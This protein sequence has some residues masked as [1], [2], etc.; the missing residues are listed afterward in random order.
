M[1]GTAKFLEKIKEEINQSSNIDRIVNNEDWDELLKLPLKRLKNLNIALQ[2]ESK[3]LNDTFWICS[4]YGMVE[5]IKVDDPKS[6]VYHI[7]EIEK[8]TN[9]RP[10]KDSLRSIHQA[11][12]FFK[13]S[14]II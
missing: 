1:L 5:Q 14:K 11:K 9:M 3:I 7:N 6:V 2:V 4:N 13:D 8:I 12:K 10:D